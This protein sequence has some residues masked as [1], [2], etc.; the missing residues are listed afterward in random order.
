MRRTAV[1]IL[2]AA[3]ALDA[4]ASAEPDYYTL[5]ALPGPPVEVAAERIE[6][7]RIELR[8]IGLAAYLDRDRIVSAADGVRLSIAE[9]AEW[10]E[11]L[12]A[13]IG[14]VLARNLRQ[15]LPGSAVVVETGAVTANGD[16]RSRCSASRPGPTGSRR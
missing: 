7:R 11:P 16:A 8:R 15:R 3:L 12:D 13:M 5:V 9:G 14:R 2:A 4:C 1:L 10:A 6:L